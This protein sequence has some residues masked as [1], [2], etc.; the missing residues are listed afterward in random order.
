MFDGQSVTTPYGRCIVEKIRGECVV[1]R[2]TNWHL[3][4]NQPPTFYLNKA[5]VQPFFNISEKVVC[6]F[7]IGIVQDIRN[8][9]IYIVTLTNWQL[10]NGKSPTLYLNEKSLS[11]TTSSSA[12]T[13]EKKAV[14]PNSFALVFKDA[15]AEKELAK[16]AYMAQRF[17]EAKLR[18][19]SAAEIMRVSFYSS[20]ACFA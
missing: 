17:E 15:L 7:G 19:A 8:D 16:V 2:P 18:Y 3:A 4:N 14:N 12:K 13:E 11:K 10:A 9:G 5:S 1:V 20:F 6:T